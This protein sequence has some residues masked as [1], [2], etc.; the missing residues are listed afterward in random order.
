MKKL[1]LGVTILGLMLSLSGCIKK[2]NLENITIYTTSYPIEYIATSL[3]GEHSTIKSIYPDDTNIDKYELTDK[4]IKDYSK[5]DMFIFSGLGKEKDYLLE[6]F[7]HNKELMIVDATQ[8]IE[9]NYKTEELWMDPSNFLMIASNVRKGLLE[10]IS[11]HYLATSI[12]T[13]YETL[14]ISISKI[15]ATL[16]LMSES[17]NYP[18][19]I[20]DNNALKFLEKYGFTV[21][22]VEEGDSLTAKVKSEVYSL[23]KSGRIDYIFTLDNDNLSDTVKEMQVNT[24]VKTL[25]LNQLNNLTDKERSLNENYISI[26]NNNIDLLKEELYN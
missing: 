19:L 16:K 12:E 8:S 2:D 9:V 4:Q 10:Y 1:C 3:Y 5:S 23:I 11:N 7:E 26:M 17:S 21:I 13:N 22:S 14:K 18:T 20:V 25:E 24:D 6:M 15:D